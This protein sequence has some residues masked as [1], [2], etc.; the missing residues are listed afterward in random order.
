MPNIV[1][2]EPFTFNEFEGQSL[3]IKGAG[4]K[5]GQ[6][7]G[8][9]SAACGLQVVPI[10]EEANYVALCTPS[11]VAEEL[12]A[13]GTYANKT[14]ID[15]SGA[16]KRSGMGEYGLMRT[17]SK[18]WNENIDVDANIYGNPGCIASAVLLG[19]AAAGLRGA[20][21]PT[22]GLIDALRPQTNISVF[23]VGG[24]SHTNAVEQDNIRLAR[25]LTDHPHVQEI[26]KASNGKLK[27]ASFMPTMC[28]VPDGLMVGI[29]GKL[30]YSM[31][32]NEGAGELSVQDVVGTHLLK[33][34]LVYDKKQA[35]TQ[36]DIDFSLAVVIDNIR[37]VTVN[38]MHLI[39]FLKKEREA[40]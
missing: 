30:P 20:L 4:G 39:R 38:V 26:E 1:D 37:F 12:L 32:L 2:S 14:V 7:L 13:S 15:L 17:E 33:H 16:A 10:A 28:D 21:T 27:V 25:R 3:Y 11:Y 36:R 5:L 22:V 19:L 35:T 8:H 31:R 24:R 29:S 6:D 9:V 40:A 34:R 23:S 18:P